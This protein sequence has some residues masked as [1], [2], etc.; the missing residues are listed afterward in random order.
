M[1]SLKRPVSVLFT[2]SFLL[3]AVSVTFFNCSLAKAGSEASFDPLD[4]QAYT[5]GHATSV[6]PLGTHSQKIV[7]SKGQLLGVACVVDGTAPNSLQGTATTVI[8]SNS[9]GRCGAGGWEQGVMDWRGEF[10]GTICN[11]APS[12]GGGN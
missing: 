4:G 3:A 11:Y 2:N 6:C 8:H 1:K 9:G 7:D 5:V 10:R 12:N